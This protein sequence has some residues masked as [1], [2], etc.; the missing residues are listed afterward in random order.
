MHLSLPAVDLERYVLRL[1][2]NHL[3]D[4]YAS[5]HAPGV[6]FGRALERVE[7]CFSYIDRKY[8]KNDK[9]V[10]FDHLNGDHMATLLYYFGNTVWSESGDEGL[11]TRL[12]YVNKIMHGLDL[13]Y[14]VSMP[15]VF[16]LVHPVGTVLGNAQYGDYLVVYQNCT[17]GAVTNVYPKFGDGTILYSRSSVLGDCR[18]GDDVV[19]AANSMIVDTNVPSN[20]MVVGQYPDQRFQPN[21]I[22]VRQR[23][24]DSQ[25]P[26]KTRATG[27]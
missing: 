19:F 23:C 15:S 27:D 11:P 24:F 12:F 4:N 3:P 17:V 10:M 13:F 6:L 26:L 2:V 21:K 16:L 20:T 25:Q 1:I 7:H 22:S 14:S 18:I 5:G 8:F 9:A